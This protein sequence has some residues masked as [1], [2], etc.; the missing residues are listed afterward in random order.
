MYMRASSTRIRR[1]RPAMRWTHGGMPRAPSTASFH[2]LQ[3][4]A[5]RVVVW[6]VVRD[7]CVVDSA[8]S[9]IVRTRVMNWIVR[10]SSAPRSGCGS[11][12]EMRE[13][14][15]EV[16]ARSQQER[17]TR[18]WI[19]LESG[20]SMGEEIW[21]SWGKKISKARSICGKQNGSPAYIGEVNKP[22]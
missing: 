20:Y 18:W 9:F 3:I 22:K 10:L 2:P 1:K 7:V 4:S 13:V 6:T 12:V 11:V 8:T 5:R 21:S 19:S 15:R 16:L 17:D 14:S